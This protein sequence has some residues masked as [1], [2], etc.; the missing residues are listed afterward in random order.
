MKDGQIIL[1]AD[2]GSEE[3]F[4]VLEEAKIAGETYLLVAEDDEED[5]DALILKQTVD[6][7]LLEY[8]VL[9]DEKEIMIISKYF[10][11]LLDDIDFELE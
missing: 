7:E 10:E 5:S 8:K 6:E 4:F 1:T 9:D 11:E 2:D 3:T